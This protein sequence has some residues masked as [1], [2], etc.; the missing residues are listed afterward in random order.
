M[1]G[2]TFDSLVIHAPQHAAQAQS[3]VAVVADDLGLLR[4]KHQSYDM[5]Q[6]FLNSK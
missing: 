2:S 6:N 5:L 4:R 3:L 1:S